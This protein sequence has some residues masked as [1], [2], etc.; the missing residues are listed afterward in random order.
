MA[1]IPMEF[2]ILSSIPLR[3]WVV[4]LPGPYDRIAYILHDSHALN[5]LDVE[6]VFRDTD[7]VSF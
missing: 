2:S 5:E 3:V 7:A 4:G 1:T 6:V